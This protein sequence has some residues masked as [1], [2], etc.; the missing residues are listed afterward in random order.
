MTRL[1]WLAA[2]ICLQAFGFLNEA[3]QG[4]S[5]C[6]RKR[7]RDIE[8]WVAFAPFDKAD[9][10]R[11]NVSLLRQCLLGKT[12]CLPVLFEYRTERGGHVWNTHIVRVPNEIFR[13]HRQ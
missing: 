13:K 5:E 3:G 4:Y 12:L 9:M 11:M 8:A 7:L 10:R 1:A 6:G 2:L